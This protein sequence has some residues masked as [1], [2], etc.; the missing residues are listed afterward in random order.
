MTCKATVCLLMLILFAL[1]AGCQPAI[2]QSQL[3]QTDSNA[4]MITRCE[5][6]DFRQN[7]EMEALLKKYDGWRVIYISEYTTGHKFG[8]SA[9][10]CFEKPMQ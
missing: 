4:R 6:V 3:R 1:L 7:G 5:E 10:V 8:T 9:A 2:I